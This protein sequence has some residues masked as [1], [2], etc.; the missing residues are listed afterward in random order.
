MKTGSPECVQLTLDQALKAVSRPQP[1]NPVH[2][3]GLLEVHIGDR[4]VHVLPSDNPSEIYR[5]R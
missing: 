1:T 2:Q 4:V 5:R 3:P